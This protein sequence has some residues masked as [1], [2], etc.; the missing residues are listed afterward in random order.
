[1]VGKYGMDEDLGPVMYRDKD[2]EDY[3]MV[4]PYSEKTAELLDEKIKKYLKDAYEE[5]K[6][7]LSDRKD[8]ID[9]MAKVLIAKEYLSKEEFELL[10]S[11]ISQADTMIADHEKQVKA[12]AKKSNSKKKTKTNKATKKKADTKSDKDVG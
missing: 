1:M 8:D 3:S 6:K 9:Q 5:A 11:D 2:K 10:M 7:I 4:K 12:L